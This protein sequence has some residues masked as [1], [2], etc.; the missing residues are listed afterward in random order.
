MSAPVFLPFSTAAAWEPLAAQRGVSKVARSN[1][2][3][4]RA[5]EKVGSPQRLSDAWKRKR[6]GFIARHV[7]QAKASGEKW[8]QADGSPTR[9]HLALIMWA[10]S[11]V[12]VQ[13]GKAASRQAYSET[14]PRAVPV[15]RERIAKIADELKEKAL[16]SFDSPDY[17]DDPYPVGL[18]SVLLDVQLP[19]V[20][21]AGLPP[22][23]FEEDWRPPSKRKTPRRRMKGKMVTTDIWLVA[24]SSDDRTMMI[25]NGHTKASYPVDYPRGYMPFGLDV[26]LKLPGKVSKAQWKSA[27]KRLRDEIYRVLLH[28]VTHFARLPW[29]KREEKKLDLRTGSEQERRKK[30]CAYYNDPEEVEA[31]AQEIAAQAIDVT[32]RL[33]RRIRSSMQAILSRCET[34]EKIEWCLTERN[35][36]RIVQKVYRELDEAG[37]APAKAPIPRKS[38]I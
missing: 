31:R 32:G 27:P 5:Y 22:S 16:A 37:L 23:S 33:R 18:V 19:V 9:R 1:R 15:D 38:L 34:W 20:P 6:D 26:T 7:A 12:P 13:L 4:M 36:R 11:P 3:F 8:F 21:I 2:G 28:E 29:M 17:A 30:V 24:P 35:K 10:Y 25:L 14:N